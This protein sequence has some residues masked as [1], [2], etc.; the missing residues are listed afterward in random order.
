MKSFCLV[1]CFKNMC[2]RFFFFLGSMRRSIE[3]QL[4]LAEIQ[5]LAQGQFSVIDAGQVRSP[6]LQQPALHL[7]LAISCG[8]KLGWSDID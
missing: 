5:H 4:Q 1:R 7:C 2:T 3:E 6:D 8:K